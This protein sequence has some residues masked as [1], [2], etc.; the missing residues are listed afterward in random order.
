MSHPK[1][2]RKTRRRRR[3]ARKLQPLTPEA[4]AAA[5]AAV[6][7][8]R[9]R[10]RILRHC[11]AAEDAMYRSAAVLEYERRLA[12]R[13]GSHT[14]CAKELTSPERLLDRTRLPRD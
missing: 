11:W 6:A 4:H 3:R 14:A 9:Q 5:A 1:F 2:R 12:L 13:H 10:G 8:A 7:E